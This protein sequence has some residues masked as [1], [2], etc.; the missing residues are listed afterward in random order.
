MWF[1]RYMK[2]KGNI[3]AEYQK[4][5]SLPAFPPD[6][7]KWVD[8]HHR[9]GR[10]KKISIEVR[11]KMMIATTKSKNSIYTTNTA[12]RNSRLSW[13]PSNQT[14]TNFFSC[15]K[16][17]LMKWMR[18]LIS[19]ITLCFAKSALCAGQKRT[20]IRLRCLIWTPR[21]LADISWGCCRGSVWNRN[22]KMAVRE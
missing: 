18:I 9:P 7:W 22:K 5:K 21:R 12:T 20:P 15:R 10:G 14:T 17:R 1:I 3:A 8:W 2:Y 16:I 4:D 13:S 19:T 6:E 11:A